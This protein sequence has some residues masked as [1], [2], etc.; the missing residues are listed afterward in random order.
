[1][2]SFLK[3][4][5]V[6][7]ACGLALLTAGCNDQRVKSEQKGYRGTALV[8]LDKI[9][10]IKARAAANKLP[11][12]IDP[13]APS[14]VLSG[15]SPLYKNVKVLGDVD[16]AEFSRLMIAMTAWVSPEQGCAYCHNVE[17]MA[18]DGLYTKIA[19]R[20]M[21]QMTRAINSEWKTHVGGTGVTCYTC[22]RGQNVPAN[23]WF[24]DGTDLHSPS[25]LGGWHGGQVASVNVADKASLPIDPFSPLLEQQNSIRVAAT[26]A[27]PQGKAGTMQQ[28]E[29]TY[30]LMMHFSKSLG[31]NCT[32]CHNTQAFAA[33]G[34]NATPQR[35]TAWYGIRMAREL[36]NEYMVPLTGV[37]PAYRLG[38]TGDVAKANCATCHQGAYKPLYGAAMAKHYPAMYPSAQPVDPAAPVTTPTTAPTAAAP[39]APAVTA[40]PEVKAEATTERKAVALVSA[41]TAEAILK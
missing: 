7:A 11:D 13:V 24:K 36:N 2:T 35:A 28:T 34:A 3:P 14:G 23:V 10:D 1:M 39:A 5:L 27:L 4:I 30:S 32:Y 33:W 19:A 6:A 31:V 21:L 9:A 17:N 37:F 12:A 8:Q 40:K 20:R 22:H 18:D 15:V 29:L 38:P 26:T 16:E 25:A 41:N